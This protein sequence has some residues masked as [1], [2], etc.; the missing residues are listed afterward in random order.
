MEAE[1]LARTPLTPVIRI[2]E[3]KRVNCYACITGCPVK[4]C[5]DSTKEKVMIDPDLCIGCGNCIPTCHHEA[6]SIIDDTPNFFSDIK[7]GTKIIVIAAPAVVSVFSG[8]HLNLNGCLKSLGVKDF[9]DVSLGAE[10]T[11]ISYLN[12]IKEKKSA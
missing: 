4:Y 5:M 8:K 11:V 3:E 7:A 2:H 9:F 1:K 10:L 6:R 12:Y